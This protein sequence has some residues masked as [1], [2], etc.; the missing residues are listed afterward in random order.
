MTSVQGAL[1][2]D[3]DPDTSAEAAQSVDLPNRQAEVL[4]ALARLGEATPHEISVWLAGQQMYRP[5]NTVA[6]RLGD[7]HDR[8]LAEPTGDKRRG[9]S[10]RFQQVWRATLEPGD[11]SFVFGAVSS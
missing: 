8:G 9:S 2:R 11:A 6:R 10:F 5:E 7:L 1:W 3:T 4:R